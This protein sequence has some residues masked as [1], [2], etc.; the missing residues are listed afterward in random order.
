MLNLGRSYAV[1][2]LYCVLAAV[3]FASST[4]AQE[5]VW[6]RKLS[7]EETLQWESAKALRTQAERLLRE[8]KPAEALRVAK[9]VWADCARIFGAEHPEMI[10]A[11]AQSARI[12]GLI[13]E[14]QTALELYDRARR[15]LRSFATDTLPTLHQ[16]SQL[17]FSR[18]YDLPLLREAT[19]FAMQHSDDVTA[20]AFSAGWTVNGKSVA[21][22][23]LSDALLRERAT[24]VGAASP[25]IT[26]WIEL[27]DVRRNIPEGTVLIEFARVDDRYAAWIIPR[28]G[29][30]ETVLLDLGSAADIERAVDDLREGIASSGGA[31]G[32]IARL[33][34]RAAEQDAIESLQA[35]AKLVFAPLLKHCADAKQLIISPAAA[36]WF[37]PWS[38]LPLEDGRYAIEQYHIQ[39][40]ISGRDVMPRSPHLVETSVPLVLA[41]AD[42]DAERPAA[43]S[44]QMT[45]ESRQLDAVTAQ[46]IARRLANVS[47]LPGTA[48]EADAIE[49]PLTEYIG[50]KPRVFRAAEAAERVVRQTVSPHVLILSTH[51]FAL[52]STSRPDRNETNSSTDG[53]AGLDNPL[54]RCGLLLA[55]SNRRDSAVHD[56]AN[57][58]ILTGWEIMGLDLRGTELVVLGA[59]DTGLGDVVD[60]EGTASLRQAFQLAGAGAVVSTLWQ[61]PDADSAEIIV[62]MFRNLAVGQTK[63]HA[64]RY[65]QLQ[66]IRKRRNSGGASHPIYWAGFTIS[67]S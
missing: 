4:L 9:Q 14:R 25:R 61:I 40:A 20:A 1:V 28:F 23:L 11:V 21:Q 7:G 55:G 13:G 34:E 53:P 65:A 33:G 24:K 43:D 38:A 18:E 58:G 26:S 54:L 35:V 64:L 39:A 12:K 8:G 66:Q 44:S 6:G 59:C 30:G 37:V 10:A 22:E 2:P 49:G 46:G 50:R 29:P 63:A 41:D 56:I 47:R 31:N 62:G 17:R 52:P 48:M 42:F 3:F 45:A 60:G 5:N 67:G 27:H 51:G 57:D 19:A 16:D 15:L 32:L 36:L